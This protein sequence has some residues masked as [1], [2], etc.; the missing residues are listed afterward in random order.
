M[1]PPPPKPMRTAASTFGCPNRE[2]D[3][4][5]PERSLGSANSLRLAFRPSLRLAFD[6]SFASR[7]ASFI[8][9][10]ACY[11]WPVTCPAASATWSTPR[12]GAWRAW[13]ASVLRIFPCRVCSFSSRLHRGWPRAYPRSLAH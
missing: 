7:A 4:F 10:Q 2:E 9:S 13:A 5:P 8:F 12:L 11:P 1:F 3:A 6:L